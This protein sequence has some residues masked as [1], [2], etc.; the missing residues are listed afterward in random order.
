VATLKPTLV[1]VREDREAVGI[2][3]NLVEKGALMQRLERAG[4]DFL[5]ALVFIFRKPVAP[6]NNAQPTASV[7]VAC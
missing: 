4:F 5:F 3:E 6:E 2:L 7:R 1:D